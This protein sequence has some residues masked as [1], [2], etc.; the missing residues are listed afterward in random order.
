MLHKHTR[1]VTW[2]KQSFYILRWRLQKGST[3]SCSWIEVLYNPSRNSFYKKYAQA[4]KIPAGRSQSRT[5][6]NNQ[7][8]RIGNCCQGEVEPITCLCVMCY[9]EAH[10]VRVLC[11][12]KMNFCLDYSWEEWSYPPGLTRRKSFNLELICF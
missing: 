7:P 3:K 5:T 4:G 12:C 1:S 9:R 10:H 6:Q 8:L 2:K 11:I